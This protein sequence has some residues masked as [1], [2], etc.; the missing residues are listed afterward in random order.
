[1]DLSTTYLGLELPSPLVAGASP[2][3]D[4]L[5]A[6]RRAE[7]A[8][9]SMLVMHSLFEEQ[10]EREQLAMHHHTEGVADAHPEAL[11]YF[12]DP[13]GQ[14]ALGPDEYLEQLTKLK[15]ALSIPI[16]GSL[17]GITTGGWVRYATLM[18]GAGAD[19]L[20]LNVYYLATDPD[21]PP[22]V[23]EQRYADILAAVKQSVTIPVALKL[24]PFFSSLVYTARRLD[25]AGADA[26]VLF[27]RF[28]QPDI[29]I[30]ALDVV[31]ALHLS[32]S[33]ALRL[34]LRW[35]AALF[36]QVGC[37]LAATGGVH[38]GRDAIKALMAG[39]N[40]VQM[41]S[42]LLRHGPEHIRTVQTELT[43][44]LEENEYESLRQ[45]I[46]S[47]SLMRCPDPANFSRTNYMKVLQSWRYR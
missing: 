31:P 36:G 38:D 10:I 42:A 46:G 35:L 20:E 39:A 9:A 40:T 28:Y 15:Q 17:N 19:A 18:Q 1:M 44:W 8:G 23:V 3:S 45:M 37:G 27:N 14:F 16:V 2:M 21:E 33:E 11:S 30:D 24:S 29:D 22:D 5:D 25:E 6:A 43:Q 47:M 34:R 32:T 26:L 7:D 41:T 13:V 12:P 4:D